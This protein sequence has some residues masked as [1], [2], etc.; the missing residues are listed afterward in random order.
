MTGSRV[1]RILA[2]DDVRVLSTLVST[3]PDAFGS[4]ER[5]TRCYPSVMDLN[6]GNKVRPRKDDLWGTN[7]D[8]VSSTRTA[9][10]RP[11]TQAYHL[12]WT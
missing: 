3:R 7:F 1:R 8:M 4:N 12:A 5:K 10:G 2:K 6:A 11:D 9:R